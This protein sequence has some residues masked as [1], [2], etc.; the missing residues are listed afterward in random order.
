MDVPAYPG[1]TW[2]ERLAACETADEVVGM[3]GQRNRMERDGT[4]PGLS[5]DERNAAVLRRLELI[6]A[7]RP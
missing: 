5:M 4:H 3:M 1:P 7:G 6:K 2:A